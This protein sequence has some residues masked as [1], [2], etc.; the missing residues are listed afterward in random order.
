V[1]D[2]AVVRAPLR[3]LQFEE[4]CDPMVFNITIPHGCHTTPGQRD[5]LARLCRCVIAKD[6]QQGERSQLR[7]GR[8]LFAGVNAGSEAQARRVVAGV[9][10]CEAG[11]VLATAL[12]RPELTANDVVRATAARQA[13]SHDR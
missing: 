1:E 11:D 13:L 4:A 8:T 2:V 5:E 3:S 6:A 9:V 12:S 10:G 7:L